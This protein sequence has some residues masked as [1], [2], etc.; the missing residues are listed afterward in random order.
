MLCLDLARVMSDEEGLTLLDLGK[1]DEPYKDR[2]SNA[3]VHLLNGSVARTRTSQAM[4]TV[5]TWPREQATNVLL[6]SP[7]LRDLSRNAL[8]RAGQLR[9]Q[10]GRRG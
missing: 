9:E 2:L 3:R 6:S 10:L 1:G 8:A 7:Q 5:R 4:H